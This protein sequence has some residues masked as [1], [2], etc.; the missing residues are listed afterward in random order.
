MR[1]RTLLATTGTG[2]AALAGCGTSLSEDQYDIE[3]TT[4][5]FQ[6]AEITISAGETVV[7][8]NPSSR[9]HSVTGYESSF[10]DGADYF[11][12]G[13]FDTEDAARDGYPESGNIPSG[14]T[15]SHAFEVAG[16]YRYFCIPHERAGMKARV[17]VE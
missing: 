6:P 9:G 12:S 11:A 3:M 4:N 14:E 15:F 17:I 5:Q 7:W 10:P 2:I 13:G 1:R 16:E 8:G